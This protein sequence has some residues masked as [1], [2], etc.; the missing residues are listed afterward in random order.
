MKLAPEERNVLYRLFRLNRD[1][2]ISGPAVTLDAAN[3]EEALDLARAAAADD[4]YGYE[5]WESS[6]LVHRRAISPEITTTRPS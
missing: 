6:R 5:V 1:G 4:L 3:D 2:R